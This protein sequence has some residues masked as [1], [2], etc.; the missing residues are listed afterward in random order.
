MI[1]AEIPF[2]TTIR[3]IAAL[4]VFLFHI[5]IRW[6]LSLGHFCENIINQGAIGMSLFF[7]LSGF[8]LTYNYYDQ[9]PEK[10][11]KQFIIRRLARIYPVYVVVG[12]LMLFVS[13]LRG[14]VVD[15]LLI[16]FSDIFL[17]QAWFPVMFNTWNNNATWSLSVE[18]FC[19][20]LFPFI[21]TKI[22]NLSSKAKIIVCAACY[23]LCVL[24]GLVYNAL[25]PKPLMAEVYALPIYRLPEF[26]LGML[27]GLLFLEKPMT[28]NSHLWIG[29]TTGIVIVYLGLAGNYLQGYVGHNF[30]VIPAFL[31]VIFLTASLKINFLRFLGEVSYSFYLIQSLPMIFLMKNFKGITRLFPF[32]ANHYLIAVTMFLITLAMAVILYKFVEEP[33]RKYIVKKFSPRQDIASS[34]PAERISTSTH[35]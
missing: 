19:Y 5:H 16:I 17:L 1:K 29:L 28:K 23:V 27:A 15:I 35:S 9:D 3:F 2:L 4:W 13:P 8:I 24:P 11:Y 31:L 26:I 10:N 22:L 21:L 20:C 7:V 18:L 30:L 32:L 12:L 34:Q 14:S 33:A 6:P 25:E